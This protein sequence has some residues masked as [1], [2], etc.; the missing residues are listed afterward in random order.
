MAPDATIFPGLDAQFRAMSWPGREYVLGTSKA[1]SGIVA[2]LPAGTWKVTQFDIMAM[3]AAT[4]SSAA[5][6]TFPFDSP[7]SRAVLF[8]F[9]QIDTD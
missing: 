3:K 8:H 9:R 2:H 7:A 5:R 4:V 6:G 1:A